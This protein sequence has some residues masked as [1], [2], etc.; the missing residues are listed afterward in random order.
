MGKRKCFK[1]ESD[2]EADSTVKSVIAPVQETLLAAVVWLI[3]KVILVV[4]LSCRALGE[5]VW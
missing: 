2:D 4:R 5:S 1:V 3:V